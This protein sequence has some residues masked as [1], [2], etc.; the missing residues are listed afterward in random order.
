MTQSPQSR[1][2]ECWDSVR[3][4]LV[5][6]HTYV[7]TRVFVLHV[8]FKPKW[9]L[10]ALMK[11]WRPLVILAFLHIILYRP[12]CSVCSV[13]SCSSVNGW[14]HTWYRNFDKNTEIICFSWCKLMLAVIRFL[15]MLVYCCFRWWNV[16]PLVWK[17]VKMPR[18]RVPTGV[19]LFGGLR[20]L[21]WSWSWY[22]INIMDYYWQNS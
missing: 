13:C 14:M 17:F 18:Y 6:V 19:H 8:I 22:I 16:P 9:E 21:V 2:E 20:H 15:N 11:I 1:D 7:M 4:E 12:V 3:C 5:C 10:V